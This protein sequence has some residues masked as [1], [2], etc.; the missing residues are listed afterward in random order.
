MGT[1]LREPNSHTISKHGFNGIKHA[2]FVA[3]AMDHSNF[4]SKY[5]LRN[6]PT[7]WPLSFWND[8]GTNEEAYLFVPARKALNQ[9]SMVGRMEE[10]ADFQ[11]ALDKLLGIYDESSEK[12]EKDNP[13][14]LGY[15]LSEQEWAQV[16]KY[17]AV[18]RQTYMS[19]CASKGGQCESAPESLCGK[20]FNFDDLFVS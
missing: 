7:H 4:Q 5:V 19:F 15:T 14:S 9:F 2:D 1:M 12:T 20:K 16:E 18:D 11:V 3:A 13:S 8:K 17:N 10:L 6:D